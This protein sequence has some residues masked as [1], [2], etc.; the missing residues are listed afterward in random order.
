[1]SLLLWGGWF[2]Y[3][4]WKRHYILDI[5]QQ[6]IN[7]NDILANYPL[8]VEIDNAGYLQINGLVPDMK[9]R[10]VLRSKIAQALPGYEIKYRISALSPDKLARIGS[11]LNIMQAEMRR[12]RSEIAKHNKT[13]DQAIRALKQIQSQTA[14]TQRLSKI[15]DELLSPKQRLV[16]WIA[17]NA[18]FFDENTKFTYPKQATAKLKTLVDLIKQAPKKLRIVV[19]GYT[20]LSGNY[21]LNQWL[22]LQRSLVVVKHLT[23]LGIPQTNLLSAGR[24]T[25]KMIAT[26]PA[27]KTINRRVEFELVQ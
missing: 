24:S 14:L 5:A 15:E 11:D 20:D 27:Q 17:N 8:N 10:D 22:A 19:I 2:G 13:T 6:T 18:I 23:R 7:S 26:N 1:M 12:M 25:E 3:K 16:R 4:L 9:A 21:N